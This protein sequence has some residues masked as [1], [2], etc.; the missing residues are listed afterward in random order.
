[1]RLG[2]D[3]RVSEDPEAAVHVAGEDDRFAASDERFDAPEVVSVGVEVAADFDQ[4]ACG[5]VGRPAAT[6]RLRLA[7]VKERTSGAEEETVST[8]E[9]EELLARFAARDAA[10]QLEELEEARE[11]RD[12][13]ESDEPGIYRYV[14]PKTP[15]AVS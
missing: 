1:M 14:G 12:V 10:R 9:N 7:S 6:V 5:R 13:W 3:L 15:L 8:V 11:L 4:V 2:D